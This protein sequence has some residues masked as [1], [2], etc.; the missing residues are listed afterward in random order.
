MTGLLRR[1]W[2]RKPEPAPLLDKADMDRLYEE[3]FEEPVST[4]A[5]FAKLLA[6]PQAD[7]HRAE[8]VMTQKTFDRIRRTHWVGLS[9]SFL[10]PSTV[11]RL[12]TQ[13][14]AETLLGRP[15]VVEP[16]AKLHLRVR[17]EG[18]E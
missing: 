3:I 2:R 8:W 14:P 15:V 17:E 5:L 9:G 4:D 10:N 6:F 11:M 16:F 12:A 1:F 7:R 13:L 18:R